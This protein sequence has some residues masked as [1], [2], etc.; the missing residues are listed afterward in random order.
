MITAL[1]IAI[2]AW[3]PCP[4]VQA[5][6]SDI[7][8][9]MTE[10]E[11]TFYFGETS[12]ESIAAMYDVGSF[13]KV[14]K[15]ENLLTRILGTGDLR[16]EYEFKAFGLDLSLKMEKNKLLVSRRANIAYVGEGGK[17]D[18]RNV[19]ESTLNCH[20]MYKDDNL[21]AAVSSCYDGQLSGFISTTKDTFE[22]SPL[23]DRLRQIISLFRNPES[24]TSVEL[25]DG[26]LVDD[27]YIVKRA[28]FPNF[29]MD[30]TQE[31]DYWYN[32]DDAV[33]DIDFPIDSDVQESPDSEGNENKMIE[34]AI[35]FDFVAYNRFS[36]I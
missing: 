36:K 3:Q 10:K 26:I 5:S 21:V 8:K 33:L 25:D 16:E 7:H 14:K 1:I 15:P 31:I 6:I 24:Q 18:R 29:T 35:V 11:L 27:L 4:G 23:T 2:T 22:I 20:M 28:I 30:D 32:D 12:P 17:A 9:Q 13:R 19:N 34:A